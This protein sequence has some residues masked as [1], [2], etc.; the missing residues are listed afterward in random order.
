MSVLRLAKLFI[1][2]ISF[3]ASIRAQTPVVVYDNSTNYS[4]RFNHT[5]NEYGDEIRLDGTA[6][7]ITQFQF[8]YYGGF[9]PTGDESARVRF[10]SNTG[11]AWMNTKDWI[12]PAATPLFE[13][14][15][16]LQTGFN[17]A[18]ISVP[19]VQVPDHFTWTVQFFGVTMTTD[20][21][22]GL[23]FYGAPTL[24]F[25]FN[26][27]WELLPIGWT[28]MRVSTVP[29]NNFAAKVMAVDAVPPPPVLS[30]AASGTSMLVSW[31]ANF[32]GLYL[33]SKAAVDSGVW[34][35]VYPQPLRVGDVFQTSIPTGDGTRIFRL[36]SQ[37]QPP[38]T[39]L[40]GADS[41]RVRWSAA[42]GGQKLQ[43]R[44]SMTAGSW[45]DVPTP[46]RP[47]GDYYE[48]TISGANTN[49]AAFFRLARMF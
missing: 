19:Y 35:P 33:E 49:A 46:T 18:T 42:V 34:T 16:P 7:Y 24:G 44:T 2:V 45:T 12:T 29:K 25:S 37:P 47:T 26:D 8:E 10:Y 41:V 9:T 11:P 15:I 14:V 38:L 1:A 21:S 39:I 17:T 22:A 27:Y 23:L 48:A 28:A 32:S 40:A 4:G 13:T 36:N 31:P 3:G 6:R 5:L 30:F 43:M 20:D